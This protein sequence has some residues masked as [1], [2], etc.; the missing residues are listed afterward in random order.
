MRAITDDQKRT[1][2]TLAGKLAMSD[3]I[4]RDMLFNRYKVDSCKQLS[5]SQARELIDSL[6]Q[7]AIT[8]N[9]WSA[10]KSFRKYKYDNLGNREGYASPAQLRKIDAMWKEV[11]FQ[12]TEKDKEDALNTFLLNHFG[13]SHIK[14]IEKDMVN[15][16]IATLKV[17]KKQQQ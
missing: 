16:V 3:D 15:K 5:H 11:S 9:V 1:I 4:Y 13:V 6:K 8:A 17:M 14:W 10:N 12:K 2:K 7:S